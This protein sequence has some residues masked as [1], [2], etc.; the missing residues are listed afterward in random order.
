MV[1][2]LR[3][4][5]NKSDEDRV[6]LA[7]HPTHHHKLNASN[8]SALTN[9]ILALLKKQTRRGTESIYYQ[10]AI[11]FVLTMFPSL[12]FEHLGPRLQNKGHFI[13]VKIKLLFH[14]PKTKLI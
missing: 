13:W 4:G 14:F 1:G 6:T 12:E 7:P 2:K 10:M 9:Q 8:I 5:A 11:L 3:E